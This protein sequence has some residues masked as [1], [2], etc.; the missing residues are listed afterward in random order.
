MAH[1]LFQ[2]VRRQRQHGDFAV[3]DHRRSARLVQQV[4]HF[5]E[6]LAFI[7]LT[8]AAASAVG[9]LVYP[10]AARVEEVG[11]ARIVAFLDQGVAGGMHLA[12]LRQQAPGV[13]EDVAFELAGTFAAA[14]EEE[15]FQR[16]DVGLA[17]GVERLRPQVQQQEGEI[18]A[19]QHEHHAAERAVQA[20]RKSTRLNSSH[21]KISYAVFCLKKK[22]KK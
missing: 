11:G 17:V 20:D 1:Q 7:E 13:A 15:L 2:D 4:G 21:Q 22:K 6:Q 9:A 18:A 10:G 3:G 19:D 16:G 12:V 14:G 5:A 8:Q